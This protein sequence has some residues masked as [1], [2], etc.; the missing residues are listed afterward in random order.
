M[1]SSSALELD[2]IKKIYAGYSGVYDLLFKR[3]FFPRQER[4]IQSL[5][6]RPGQKILDVGVG[7][8]LSL[9]IYPRYA[10]VMGIDVS[11]GMLREAAKKI[12]KHYLSHVTLLEMDA[13]CLAFEDDTFDYVI[14]AHVITV[15][16]DPV[17][18]LR[19]VKR[20]VKREG[21]IVIINHFQ[22][23]NPVLATIEEWLTPFYK[24][25]GWR[26]LALPEIVKQANLQIDREYRLSKLDPWKVIFA[27][28]NK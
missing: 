2:D 11:S 4:V 21:R 8:G 3:F 20:V 15:V 25:M 24:R 10:R 19:E 18:M 1:R 17:K 26:S 23:A 22:S 14:A 5:P 28:N 16:P 7:T 13:S 6:I 12:N 9:P 27:V